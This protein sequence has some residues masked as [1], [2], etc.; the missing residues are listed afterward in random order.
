MTRRN[1]EEAGGY[2]PEA[3]KMANPL[4]KDL[5]FTDSSVEVQKLRAQYDD[6][7]CRLHTLQIPYAMLYPAKL[8]VVVKGEIHFF[9]PWTLLCS[10]FFLLSSFYD[11]FANPTAIYCT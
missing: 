8:Q 2:Q 6:V 4:P 5:Y 11:C 9:P 7:K 10:C 3:A 1:E